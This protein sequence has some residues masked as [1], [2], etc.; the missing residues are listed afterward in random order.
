MSG[1][2]AKIDAILRNG[3]RKPLI[4]AIEGVAVGGGWSW[5]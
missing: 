5:R 1:L 4:A 2:P 3:C